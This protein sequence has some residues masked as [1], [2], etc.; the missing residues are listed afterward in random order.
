MAKYTPSIRYQSIP[1]PPPSLTSHRLFSTL[2]TVPVIDQTPEENSWGSKA[3][4]EGTGSSSWTMPFRDGLPTPPS[5]MTGVAYNAISTV[6]FGG[7][8][9]GMP[10]HLYGHARPHVDSTSS[11]TMAA[12]KPQNYLEALATEH[13]NSNK[14]SSTGAQPRIPS[15]I[16]N[17]KGTLAEF[18]AQVRIPQGMW[19]GENVLMV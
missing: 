11:A 15:S 18:A 10:S 9:N 6:N 3:A 17:S 16:N 5:D 1:M 12:M 19:E 7:K 13:A 8:S 4:I 14:S 2:G